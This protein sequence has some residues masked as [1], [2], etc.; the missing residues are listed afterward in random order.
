MSWTWLGCSPEGEAQAVGWSLR[1]RDGRCLV[2]PAAAS[3]LCDRA[4]SAAWLQATANHSG[5]SSHLLA[6]AVAVS[7][8]AARSGQ[9]VVIMETL[10]PVI[11]DS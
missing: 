4:Y 11:V 10:Q 3:A 7:V 6:V 1:R 2:L 5:C 9:V 8:S